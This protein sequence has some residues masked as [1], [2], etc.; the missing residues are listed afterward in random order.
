MGKDNQRKR[1][2]RS[3]EEKSDEHTNRNIK[4]GHWYRITREKRR[5]KWK[6]HRKKQQHKNKIKKDNQTE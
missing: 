4:Q 2:T 3:K 6:R 5:K 1:D